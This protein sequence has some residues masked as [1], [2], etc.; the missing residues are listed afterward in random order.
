MTSC[1]V[2]YFKPIPGSDWQAYFSDDFEYIF[3]VG[4]DFTVLYSAF[5]DS[6]TCCKRH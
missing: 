2:L 4:G 5:V 6:E 3:T 1:F